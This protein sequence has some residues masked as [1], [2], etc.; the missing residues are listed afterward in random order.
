MAKSERIA[1]K[2]DPNDAEDFDVSEAG[3]Q[4]GLAEREGRR[5]RGRPK[6]SGEPTKQLVSIRIDKDALA[7]MKAAGP[8][9][10]S[11]IN[12]AVRKAAGL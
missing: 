10:Q 2:A 6:G 4:Q 9:W 1:L 5:G 12:E 11:R 7:A 8:G 3:L